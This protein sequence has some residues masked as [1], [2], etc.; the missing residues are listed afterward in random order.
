MSKQQGNLDTNQK[1][2]DAWNSRDVDAFARGHKPDIVLRTPQRPPSLGLGDFRGWCAQLLQTFPDHYVENNP[3]KVSF[4]G[5]DWTCTIAGCSGTMT[6]PMR[7]GSGEIA[8]T[9]RRF[10]LDVCTVSRWDNGQIAEKNVSYDF[11]AFMG[12]IG[13]QP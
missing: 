5:G 12:Q 13:L 2:T 3:S 4:A 11:A 9:G 8:P 1:L 10:D 7:T 6:G